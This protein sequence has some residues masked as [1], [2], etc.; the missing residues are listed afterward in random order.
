M[1]EG[2]ELPA[3]MRRVLAGRD[4]VVVTSRDLEREGSARMW[5]AL[6]PQ[7]VLYLLT[8]SVSLKARRWEEDPWVR[9]RAGRE[10]TEGVVEPVTLAEVEDD[11]PLL[12]TRFAMA[13]AATVEALSWMLDSGSHRLFR[14][15]P[16]G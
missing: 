13:G 12:L 10:M 6:S 11:V 4:T 14:V 1:A 3:E 15:R 2:A 16:R 9:V 5:F 7:G 8:P